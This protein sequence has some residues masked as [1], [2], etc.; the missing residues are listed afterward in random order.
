MVRQECAVGIFWNSGRPVGDFSEWAPATTIT[1][2]VC[3]ASEWV[4]GGH[5]PGRSSSCSSGSPP[6]DGDASGDTSFGCASSGAPGDASGSFLGGVSGGA[7]GGALGA[8]WVVA[9]KAPRVALR[10]TSRAAPRAVPRTAPR[11]APRAAPRSAPRTASWTLSRV[12]PREA[13]RAA[14]RAAPRAAP[15]AEPRVTPR[16]F[17]E[18]RVTSFLNFPKEELWEIITSLCS[19]AIR[20]T[21]SRQTATPSSRRRVLSWRGYS[22]RRT[23]TSACAPCAVTSTTTTS[24]SCRALR[25]HHGDDLKACAEACGTRSGCASTSTRSRRGPAQHRQRQPRGGH[26]PPH[27]RAAGCGGPCPAE[28][29]T[30]AGSVSVPL[31]AP[32]PDSCGRGLSREAPRGNQ[33]ARHWWRSWSSR[34][35]GCSRPLT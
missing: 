6:N 9:W 31:G 30:A 15:R 24:R 29:P 21:S 13:P 5:T 1:Y 34:R 22:S 10:T 8:P 4:R 23:S 3:Q 27:G 20:R 12:A 25:A 19:G 33:S 17:D 11:G 18:F 2:C 35:R 7:S 32:S 26:G 16:G 14:S 28:R